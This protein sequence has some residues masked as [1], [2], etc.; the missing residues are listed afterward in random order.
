M[1]H[2][3]WFRAAAGVLATVF[4]VSAGG[5]LPQSVE[6]D[7]AVTEM[8]RA[9]PSGW[10]IVERKN[11]EIP[12]GHHWCGEYGGTKGL[13][14]VIKGVRPVHTEFRGRDGTWRAVPIGTEALEVWLMPGDYS[15]SFWS[16]TCFHRPIQPTGV[17]E[18]GPVHVYA[19]PSSVTNSEAEFKKLLAESTAVQSPDSPSNAPETLTWKTWRNDLSKAVMAS[20]A[21]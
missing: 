12:W 8:A 21:K 11:G 3:A 18:R 7:R 1:S 14:V 15:D 16:W 9:L 19:R 20:K 5:A 17:V 4:L 2:R 6:L 10:T 13:K